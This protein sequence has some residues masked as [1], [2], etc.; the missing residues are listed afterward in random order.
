[1]SANA[2]AFEATIYP[3]EPIGSA[4]FALL[5]TMTASLSALLGI[6]FFLAGAWPVVGFLSVDVLLLYLAFRTVRRRARRREH[7]RLDQSGLCVRRIDP[8]GSAREWRFEPYWVQV[9]MDGPP[10]R[11]SWLT[12]ASHGL[13][14]RVGACLTP[15]ERLD[16][17]RSLRAAL[18]RYR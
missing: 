11:D 7:I 10:R 12:L 2:R 18:R 16:L 1:M 3:A 14:L 17:A 13:T 6:G 15:A 8:D 9:R 5:M 4:G